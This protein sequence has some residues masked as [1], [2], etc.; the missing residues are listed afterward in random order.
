VIETGADLS[1]RCRLSRY[2]EYINPRLVK[3]IN[4]VDDFIQQTKVF[5]MNFAAAC[6]KVKGVSMQQDILSLPVDFFGCAK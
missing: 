2:A 1:L 4:G 5:R 6:W 3:S